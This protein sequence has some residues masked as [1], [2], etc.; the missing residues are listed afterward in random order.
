ML[1]QNFQS[2]DI[3]DLLKDDANES[4][5]ARSI[6]SYKRSL[7]ECIQKDPM[8]MNDLPI[9]LQKMVDEEGFSKGYA[10]SLLLLDLFGVS[11]I[12]H[13]CLSFFRPL[14]TKGFFHVVLKQCFLIFYHCVQKWKSFVACLWCLLKLGIFS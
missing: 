7:F 5:M 10:S 12:R 9:K 2:I 13:H 8:L 4:I 1:A 11:A 3:D 14:Y 6:K